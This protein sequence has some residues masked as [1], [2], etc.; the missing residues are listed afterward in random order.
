MRKGRKERGRKIKR[1]GEENHE[2]KKIK[3]LHFT[4][5][6]SKNSQKINLSK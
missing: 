4:L 6:F 2:S 3:F 5:I 1:K